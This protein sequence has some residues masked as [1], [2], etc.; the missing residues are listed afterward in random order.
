[1]F[2]CEGALERSEWVEEEAERGKEKKI[3]WRM[4]AVTWLGTGRRSSAP[5]STGCS[6]SVS[7]GWEQCWALQTGASV[8]PAG[9]ELQWHTPS[10]GRKGQVP[11]QTSVAFCFLC[12]LVCLALC[13]QWTSLTQVHQCA[14]L[15]LP[16]SSFCLCS[17]WICSVCP[18]NSKTSPYLNLVLSVFGWYLNCG[19]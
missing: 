3:F 13:V 7:P 5:I 9:L 11:A 4:L 19:L 10:C 14:F 1:M 12:S 15:H 16:L 6:E 8:E 18:A 2:L 17:A